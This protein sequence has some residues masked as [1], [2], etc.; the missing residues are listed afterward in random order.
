MKFFAATLVSSL[1]AIA[2]AAP[3]LQCF[4]AQKFGGVTVSPSTFASGDTV[5]IDADFRCA[6]EYY[7]HIPKYTD[8]YIEV[9]TNNNGNEPPILL[10]RRE[11][12]AGAT[13]D[14]FTVQIPHAYY[15]KDANYDIVMDVTFASN[16]TDG[17][18][19]YSVGGV[20]AGV[21]ITDATN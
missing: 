7:G 16:G 18:P 4:E 19:Y 13:S 17:S 11:P 6:V 9:P 10:A 20:E 12:A 8:Y 1:L 5:Q 21:I 15:F 3:A 2:S 14:S